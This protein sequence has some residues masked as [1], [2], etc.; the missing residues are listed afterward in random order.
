[1][2]ER[3][4]D[5]RKLLVEMVNQVCGDINVLEYI[6]RRAQEGMQ[7]TLETLGGHII[8]NPDIQNYLD[9]DLEVMVAFHHCIKEQFPRSTAENLVL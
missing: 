9:P 8:V 7:V 5:D 1:M 4:G 6:V 2:A 3:L